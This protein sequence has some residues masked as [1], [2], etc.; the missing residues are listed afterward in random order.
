MGVCGPLVQIFAAG[1]K[2]SPHSLDSAVDRTRERVSTRT[3]L[4]ILEVRTGKTIEY[5]DDEARKA[6]TKG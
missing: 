2:Y 6:G 5:E 4:T 1:C 3:S